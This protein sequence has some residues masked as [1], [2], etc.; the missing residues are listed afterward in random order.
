MKPT[1]KDWKRAREVMARSIRSGG[2]LPNDD[3]ALLEQLLQTN[4]VRYGRIHAEEKAL[5]VAELNP[6]ARK[7][8]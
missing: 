7:E 1:E 8:H 3:V 2:V 4:P 6:M 5:A